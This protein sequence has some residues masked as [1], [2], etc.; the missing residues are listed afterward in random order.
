MTVISTWF[1]A[2]QG[3]LVAL[4]YLGISS[5]FSSSAHQTTHV[6]VHFVMTAN[7]SW[8]IL[9]RATFVCQLLP[10]LHGSSKNPEW[11]ELEMQKKTHWN[12]KCPLRSSLHMFMNRKKGIKP[13]Y[14]GYSRAQKTVKD[15]IE[16]KSTQTVSVHKE[17]TMMNKGVWKWGCVSEGTWGGCMWIN[18]K[19][20][21]GE[22]AIAKH[23]SLNLF[24]L[25][26]PTKATNRK[27][28]I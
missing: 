24:T 12:H 13:N 5:W 6:V 15:T 27:E 16:H 20:L 3:L 23:I 26:L 8:V 10:K 11:T 7:T 28:R 25:E 18:V 2:N 17:W 1:L 22:L 19:N 4:N 21:K 9:E 14:T